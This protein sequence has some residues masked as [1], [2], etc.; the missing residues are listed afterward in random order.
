MRSF[1]THVPNIWHAFVLGSQKAGKREGGR[2]KGERILRHNRVQPLHCEASRP[3]SSGLLLNAFWSLFSPSG[4]QGFPTQSLFS[5][6]TVAV[7]LLSHVQLFHNPM[8]CSP[9][10]SSVH[11][12]LQGR[13]LKWVAIPFSRG[14]SWPRD[15]TYVSCTGRQ[16]LYL[17][18]GLRVSAVQSVTQSYPTLC[19]PMDYST[20]G[21]PVHHSLP[22]ITQTHVH[23]VSDAIQPSHPLSSPF[24]PA[25]NLPASGSFPVSQFFTSGSQ[26]IGVSASASVLPMNIRD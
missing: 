22:E 19:D 12:I 3:W 21:F 24:P 7:E 9:P 14:S 5:L 16:I 2:H 8:D 20:A 15:Q 10:G 18:S 17:Y 1:V 11:G 6:C 13:I 25:F 26:S 23:P 4:S